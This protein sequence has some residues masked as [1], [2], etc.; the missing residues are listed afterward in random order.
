MCVKSSGR[1]IHVLWLMVV[2]LQTFNKERCHIA[3]LP[4]TRCLG[5]YDLRTS[6]SSEVDGIALQEF[7]MMMMACWIQET[8]QGRLLSCQGNS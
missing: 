8:L 1:G 2:E 3:F 5:C 6:K 4:L 7:C